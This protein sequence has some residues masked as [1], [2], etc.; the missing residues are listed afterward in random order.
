MYIP[1]IKINPRIANIL[2]NIVK[3]EDIIPLLEGNI[4]RINK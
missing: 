1:N 4:A 2:A 3:S